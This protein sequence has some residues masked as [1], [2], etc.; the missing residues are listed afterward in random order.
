[1]DRSIRCWDMSTS[2][3]RGVLT[4][5]EGGHREAVSCLEQIVIDESN[6]TSSCVASG[7]ADG[8]VIIWGPSGTKQWSG[9]QGA[10]VTSLLSSMDN[11]GRSFIISILVF[12]FVVIKIDFC[13]HYSNQLRFCRL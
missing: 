3:C 11:A 4:S 6:N 5:S 7:G 2:Q 8:E 13:C 1:M 9:P 10:T 12:S